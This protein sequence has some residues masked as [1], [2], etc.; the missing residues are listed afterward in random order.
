MDLEKM[1]DFELIRL[2]QQDV[3]KS[4]YVFSKLIKT[5]NQSIYWH[6][7]R[8]CKNHEQTND[9]LQNVWIKVWRNLKDFKFESSFYT[10]IYRISK[11]E[12]IN[13]LQK[14]KKYKSIDVDETYLEILAGYEGLE[15]FT[16][17]EISKKLQEAIAILPEKQALVFQLKFFE[18]MKY[19]EIAEKLNLSEGGL[20]ASYHHAVTKIQDFLLRQLNLFN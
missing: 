3:S 20:K 6:I 14:E 5:H 1:N 17:E 18:D 8:I 10:W 19:S 15:N 4:E 11:N 13:F 16:A 2:F 7:R 12:T 9:I